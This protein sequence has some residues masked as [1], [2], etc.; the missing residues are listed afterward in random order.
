MED[1]KISTTIRIAELISAYRNGELS[2]TEEAILK[3]WIAENEDNEKLFNE[4]SDPDKAR[5][6]V[7]I[8]AGYQN[9][10][11]GLERI[12][13]LAQS[14]PVR[15]Q[16]PVKRLFQNSL[17]R[18]SAAMVAFTIIGLGVYYYQQARTG[19]PVKASRI[20]NIVPGTN[21][22][23]LTLADGRRIDLK[24]SKEAVIVAANTL[25][26]NDGSQIAVMNGE[27]PGVTS[28][29]AQQFN[30]ITTPKGGQYQIILP[31]QTKVWLNAASS[32]QYPGKF[33]GK[34]REVKLVGEAYFEVNHNAD[35]P[36]IVKSG[37]QTLKVL[38][39]H[40]NVNAYTDDQTIKTTLL[41]GA[42]MVYGESATA[43]KTLLPGQQSAYSTTSK[44]ITLAQVD[45]E[46]AV[47]WKNGYFKFNDEPL[48]SIMRKI[49][50]W[51]DVEIIYANNI[52][53]S[54]LFGGRMSKFDNISTVLETLELTGSVHFKIEERRI[55]V[56]K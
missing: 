42:V 9:K 22:A 35:M 28:Q 29:T 6:A 13:A 54:L 37:A 16:S 32:L 39:T 31:D 51:Y 20:S 36:F 4:L 11:A 17:F 15:N 23:V 14:Q 43:A 44:Q 52:N 25:T 18:Y 7:A 19:Q 50:R 26:Y 21:R 55:T 47:A 53:K 2:E 24:E 1:K 41:K 8:M 34:I 38:G 12:M 27:Q 45:T 5:E 33:I 49:S 56:M 10:A 46:E 40:F 48:E 30:T 3:S